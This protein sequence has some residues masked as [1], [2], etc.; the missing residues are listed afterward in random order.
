M[1]LGR[2]E[3]M[4]GVAAVPIVAQPQLGAVAAETSLSTA[5]RATRPAIGRT[6]AIDAR[7]FFTTAWAL[8]LAAVADLLEGR[9]CPS[10]APVDGER[11]AL[12][13]AE[14]A[15]LGAIV[16]AG[17]L[18]DA[19]RQRS[20]LTAVWALPPALVPGRPAAFL[21]AASS[22]V[23]DALGSYY[24]QELAMAIEAG[25]ALAR[26]APHSARHLL[27]HIAPSVAVPSAKTIAWLGMRRSRTAQCR[28]WEQACREGANAATGL[29]NAAD[30]A[31]APIHLRIDQRIAL[32]VAPR[33]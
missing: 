33:A 32:F 25:C 20:E 5:R 16:G 28:V 4:G 26:R 30:G 6:V 11:A 10:I 29:W 24:L 31:F 12:M 13:V 22:V 21:V 9:S 8:K 27:Q 17:V 1:I 3:F 23:D 2:R 15:G 19:R 18:L 14:D 7:N